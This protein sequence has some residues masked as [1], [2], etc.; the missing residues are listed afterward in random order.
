MGVGIAGIIPLA[1]TVK[2]CNKEDLEEEFLDCYVY[3]EN[4]EVYFIKMDF[5]MNNFKHFSLEFKKTLKTSDTEFDVDWEK[6]DLLD[7][8]NC[9]FQVLEEFFKV[10][11]KGYRPSFEHGRYGISVLNIEVYRYLLIYF[12]SYKAYLEEYSTLQD[13]EFLTTK[14]IENPLAKVV[15]YGM[16]G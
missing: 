11:K 10:N 15:K 4:Q 5:L 1:F 12:G 6:F 13:M 8:D 3:D 9:N 16:Y 7:F 2:P 14:A